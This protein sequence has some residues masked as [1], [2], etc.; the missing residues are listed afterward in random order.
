MGSSRLR[1]MSVL[2]RDHRPFSLCNNYYVIH[3][4]DDYNLIWYYYSAVTS[5]ICSY[6]DIRL[7]GGSSSLEGRVEVCYN[8][9]WG[10]VCD[11][12]WGSTDANVAC[13]QLGFSNSGIF[14]FFRI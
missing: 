3:C 13:G 1:T 4:S 7:V 8:N 9:Q 14:I 5:T 2:S 6:G 10:T 12:L 11:D